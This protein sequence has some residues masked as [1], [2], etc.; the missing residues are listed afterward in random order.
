ML[1]FGESG[2]SKVR[3]SNCQGVSK[4][5][6][7]SVS[8]R[9]G[10]KRSSLESEIHSFRIRQSQRVWIQVKESGLL[11]FVESGKLRIRESNSHCMS[12]WSLR[13]RIR[14]NQRVSVK[15]SGLLRFGESGNSKVR[16]SNSQCLRL[17]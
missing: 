9:M 4:G 16:E 17:C 15:E 8:Q 3:K 2:N 6:Q 5:K 7:Q 10:V 1:I 14:Q 11:R 13:F 12:T